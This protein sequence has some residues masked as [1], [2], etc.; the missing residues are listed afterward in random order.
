[1]KDRFEFVRQ[2]LEQLGVDYYRPDSGCFLWFDL[3]PYLSDS[4][5]GTESEMKLWKEIYTLTGVNIAPGCAFHSIQ[6]GWFRLCY[7]SEAIEEAM[8]RLAVVI[9][10]WKKQQK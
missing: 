2:S 9:D 3:R 1:L 4:T 10:S 7:A 5:G 6:L 8:K